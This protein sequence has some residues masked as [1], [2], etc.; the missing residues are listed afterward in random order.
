MW[1]A[2]SRI[3]CPY[4]TGSNLLPIKFPG[5]ALLALLEAPAAA[6]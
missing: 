6:L 5:C 1:P 4:D 3:D 2:A